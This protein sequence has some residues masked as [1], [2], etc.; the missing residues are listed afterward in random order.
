VSRYSIRARLT[1]GLAILC[2]AVI[3]ALII[4]IAEES[5]HYDKAYAENLI[6]LHVIANSNLPQD[7]D[8]KLIVRDQVLKEAERILAEVDSKEGAYDLLLGQ[9]ERLK[10][11]AQEVVASAGYDYPVQVRMGQFVFPY[12]EYGS[13]ALPEGWYDAVRVEIGAAQGDN[14]WCVL[15]PPLCLAELEGANHDLATVTEESSPGNRLVF[16]LKLW[17]RIAETQYA[18]AVKKWLQASAAG[19][20][21]VSN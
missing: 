1:W 13:M 12:R 5:L 7:Q 8:L 9:Q 2:T 20:P 4:Q 19:F 18:Q 10:E 15:F 21:A 3:V 16:R 11:K 6:R 17:E 14:W